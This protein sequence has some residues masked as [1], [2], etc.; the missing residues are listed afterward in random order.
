MVTQAD[1]Q[2]EKNDENK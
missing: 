2:M 1:Q